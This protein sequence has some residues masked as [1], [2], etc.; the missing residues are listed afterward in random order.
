MG[1]RPTLTS[2]FSVE[3]HKLHPIVSTILQPSKQLAL[4]SS[5]RGFKLSERIT[6]LV[7]HSA[8]YTPPGCLLFFPAL[9]HYRHVI[10]KTYSNT[11]AAAYLFF[12]L[13]L[14]TWP[15]LPGIYVLWI[16]SCWTASIFFF[17]TF[18]RP[19]SVEVPLLWIWFVNL[20]SVHSSII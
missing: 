19:K 16:F 20:M 7:S 17:R 4:C 5:C 1:P 2:D 6:H 12:G 15:R 9:W 8:V 14:C 18:F 10:L 3:L 13:S 11:R